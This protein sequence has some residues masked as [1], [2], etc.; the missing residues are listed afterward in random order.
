MQPKI[1]LALG[2]GGARGLAHIGVL[3]VFEREHI[4]IFQITGTSI[5]SL[6]G[7]LYAS[8]KSADRVEAYIKGLVADPIFNELEMKVFD[9][10]AGSGVIHQLDQYINSIKMYYSLLKTLKTKSIY[11]KKLVKQLF[12]TYPD[13]NIENLPIPF[14][15]IA[16]DLLS[17]REIVITEGSLKLAVMASS[18]IPGIFPPVKIEDLLLIDGAA[19]DSIPVQIVKGRG[20]K[21]VVAVDVSH[22][23]E[24]AGELETGLQIINRAEDIVT[25]HLTQ[26]RLAGADLVIKPKVRHYTW[27][28]VK[29][30]DELIKSG[31]TAAE[32]SLPQLKHIL[33]HKQRSK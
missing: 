33:E 10:A 11:N 14:V 27:A 19:T 16:T 1:G 8:Y 3:R 30:M 32:Q 15:A 22:C 7:G 9:S 25:Y 13:Q 6:I 5:G 12:K 17:G 31:E 21:Y 28:A 2:G 26:E 18:A 4:P 29:H 23:V 24:E 20:A